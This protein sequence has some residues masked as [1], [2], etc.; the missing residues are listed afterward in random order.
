M[1]TIEIKIYEVDELNEKAK[2]K[3]IEWYRN[4]NDYAFLSDDL[5]YNL[6]ELLQKHKITPIKDKKLY[7]SLGYSQ[8]DGAVFV[9]RFKWRGYDVDIKHSGHYYHS[10]SKNITITTRY[11]NDA[12]IEIYDEFEKV[13]KSICDEIERIGYEQIEYEDD[14]KNIIDNIR[15]NEYTFLENGE[16]FN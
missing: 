3:A 15:M 12:K 5:N 1:Q 10:N 11:G 7:Y 6:D 14:D 9:G 2:S 13:F 16:R 4:L 8:G